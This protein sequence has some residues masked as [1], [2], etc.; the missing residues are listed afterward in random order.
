MKLRRSRTLAT[1]AISLALVLAPVSTSWAGTYYRVAYSPDLYL[2]LNTSFVPVAS[3]SQYANDPQKTVLSPLS[4]E[5]SKY[6]WSSVIFARTTVPLTFGTESF[7]RALTSGEWQSV[8]YPTPITGFL[9]APAVY[10]WSTNGTEVFWTGPDARNRAMTSSEY[11]AA[12]YPAVAVQ[13]NRG[14]QKLSWK[15]TIAY[16][17]NVSSG[18]GVSLTYAE[19]YRM[20]LPTAASVSRFPNDTL[21]TQSGST[22][23]YYYG[24]T[25][26][27]PITLAE[28]QAA[29]SP[30]PSSC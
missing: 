27:G 14:F 13:S 9:L 17:Y 25:F 15:P 22:T 30:A 20:A 18:V 3:A 4:T 29:G 1:A 12:G 23:V 24:P 6:S 21:C 8:G 10:R 7:N 19:W 2:E 11:A 5:Y 16:M 28:Y 26:S